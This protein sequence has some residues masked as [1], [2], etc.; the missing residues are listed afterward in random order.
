MRIATGAIAS[1][2]S[3]IAVKYAGSDSTLGLIAEP[4]LGGRVRNRCDASVALAVDVGLVK[5][6]SFHKEASLEVILSFKFNSLEGRLSQVGI[7]PTRTA[8]VD[9]DAVGLLAV[10]II[11]AGLDPAALVVNAN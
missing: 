1:D 11:D 5:Q 4:K 2:I 10:E 7:L 8:G 9:H 3:L 6:R